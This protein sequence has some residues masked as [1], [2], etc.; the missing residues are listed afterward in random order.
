MFTLCHEVCDPTDTYPPLLEFEPRNPVDE[1][2]T[3]YSVSHPCHIQYHFLLLNVDFFSF[4]PYNVLAH[5]IKQAK[6][7]G[8]KFE[9]KI[10]DVSRVEVRMCRIY[11]S[12]DVENH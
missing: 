8:L 1:S 11:P 10:M 9:N 5:P 2:Q 6:A 7:A 3:S 12:L 4:Q